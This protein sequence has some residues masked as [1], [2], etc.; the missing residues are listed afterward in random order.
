MSL[1]DLN[2]G[3]VPDQEPVPEGQYT[4]RIANAEVRTS[5]KTGGQYLYVLNEIE[6]EP[7]ALPI[8]KTFMFP[9]AQDDEATVMTRNRRLK[10]FLEAVGL[11][12][13]Q[14]FEPQD[15]IGQTYSAFLGV[16][17]TDEYGTR[18]YIKRLL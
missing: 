2:L 6:G 3:D 9:T 17:E 4:L 12:P 1:I 13:T 16:E 15:L 14:P 18:N 8:S 5:G 11:D 7:N 10:R